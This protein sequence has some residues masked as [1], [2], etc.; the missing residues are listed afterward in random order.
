M[1]TF[2]YLA[3]QYGIGLTVYNHQSQPSLH[4]LSIPDSLVYLMCKERLC[5]RECE[6]KLRLIILEIN[7]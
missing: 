3:N 1:V 2:V 6:V 7:E 5:S 4:P